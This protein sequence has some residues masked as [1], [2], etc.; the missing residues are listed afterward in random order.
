[1]GHGFTHAKLY[2]GLEGALMMTMSRCLR[3]VSLSEPE[4]Q[5]DDTFHYHKMYEM[6]LLYNT[7]GL[8]LVTQTRLK[9][10]QTLSEGVTKVTVSTF[11][12]LRKS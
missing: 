9:L 1:M 3:N 10:K 6:K 4:C 8:E 2:W 7:H 5:G 11:L 12:F